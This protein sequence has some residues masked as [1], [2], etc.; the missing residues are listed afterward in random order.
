[1]ALYSVYVQADATATDGVVT[2]SGTS[3]D[4]WVGRGDDVL[5]EALNNVL[6][7]WGAGT[8][9][10]PAWADGDIHEVIMYNAEEFLF[11]DTSNDAIALNGTWTGSDNVY[12]TFQLSVEENTSEAD[13]GTF[14]TWPDGSKTACAKINGGGAAATPFAIGTSSLVT[15]QNM[16]I[17]GF[18]GAGMDGDADIAR[19]IKIYDCGED[20]DLNSAAKSYNIW[21]LDGDDTAA[22]GV[23]HGD[24]AKFNIYSGNKA[25]LMVSGANDVVSNCIFDMR[26][27][28]TD[29]AGIRCTGVDGAEYSSNIFIGSGVDNEF[30]IEITSAT[31]YGVRVFNNLFINFNGSGSAPLNEGSDSAGHSFMLVDGNFYYNCNANIFNGDSDTMNADGETN[32]TTLSTNPLFNPEG[33]DYRIVLTEELRTIFDKMQSAPVMFGPYGFVDDRKIFTGG[34]SVNTHNEIYKFVNM[35][36]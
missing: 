22:L 15:W 14:T 33:H 36:V 35:E 31:V 10:E 7:T 28:I 25:R 32:A 6:I 18:T 9:A 5:I 23:S 4:P 16:E 27:G 20:I 24:S 13:G 3:G 17:H 19:N 30:A 11:Y 34:G 21:T 26:D 1:M 8:G 12:R 29:L 2:G